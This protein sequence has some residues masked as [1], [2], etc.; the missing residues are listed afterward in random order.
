MP[1]QD[2]KQTTPLPGMTVADQQ[3]TS[4]ANDKAKVTSIRSI[5]LTWVDSVLDPV[6]FTNSSI[7]L[8]EDGSWSQESTIEDR[9]RHSDWDVWI[10]LSI[11]N[12]QGN[13]VAVLGHRVWFQDLDAGEKYTKNAN[14]YSQSVRDGFRFLE[15]YQW[16]IN[17]K[18]SIVR[19]N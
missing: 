4:S 7:T 19:D 2:E 17:M 12:K 14:G 9:S 13:E 15:E 16:V 10:D 5:K 1:T 6:Y 3:V 18:K 11:V 8:W